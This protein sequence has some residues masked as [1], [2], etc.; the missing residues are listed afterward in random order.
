MNLTCSQKSYID[1]RVVL[2]VNAGVVHPK[3][4]KNAKEC[5]MSK[6]KDYTI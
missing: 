1:W 2:L 4:E 5:I 6:D 3:Q